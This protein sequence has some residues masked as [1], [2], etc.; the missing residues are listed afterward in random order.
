VAELKG[1][2]SL[3]FAP[4]ADAFAAN[5]DAG[6]EIG[7][8]IC[9]YQRG[10]KVVDIWA[11]LKDKSIDDPWREDSLVPVFSVTKALAAL[12]F[13]ILANRKKFDYDRPVAHYWPDFA[14]AGK[15]EITC[16]QLLEH[17][18]GLYAIEKPLQL[19]DFAD[20]YPRVYNALILQR[21]LFIPGSNQ[22]YGAQVWGAYA[23]ELFRQVAG[24]SIGQFFAREVAKKLGIDAH[25][26]LAP[27]ND[28]KV[29]TLYPVSV[30]DRL[31]AL[32]PDMIMGETTE[33]RIGRA[34]ISGNNSIEQAYM[35]P[36]AGPK[37]VEIF[38]EP[39]VR[40]LE[41]PWVNGVANARSLA[42]LMN[43]LALG[44]K[45]GKVQFAGAELMRELTKENPLRYDLVLQK[46]LGWNL[47]FLKE[48]RWLY[49]PNV[50]AFGHSGMG[51][52]L[53]LADPKAKL[54]FGYVCNKMDYKIRPD[55][56]LRLCRALYEC[57]R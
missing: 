48:E 19:S 45:L 17:R 8:A 3:Q 2:W 21:P 44:G 23:G 6:Q 14:L 42:T 35:N 25:I 55:K 16:R 34:F 36:S 50:E 4:L 7:A 15:G 28:H 12:C 49:S 41:L 1:E 46:P 26:G 57:V 40:R 13:L 18:A 24:E 39:W 31:A 20:N 22:G 43:V 52:S 5:F 38:N 56:T 53:A 33:G 51:G 54:S 9:V 29:A 30:F 27:A 37:S 47:G 11:G 10:K 32:V